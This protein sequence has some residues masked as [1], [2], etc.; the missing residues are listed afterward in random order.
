MDNN[1]LEISASKDIRKLVEQGYETDSAGYISTALD[2]F[3]KNIPQF[4][5][6]TLIYLGASSLLSQNETLQ[7][8][9]SLLL[10]PLGFGAFIVAQKIVKNQDYTFKNFFDGYNRFLDV[11]IYYLIQ[12]VIVIAIAIAI[13]ALPI[14]LFII[15][16]G[17]SG[18][19]N[20]SGITLIIIILIAIIVLLFAFSIGL[21]FLFAPNLLWFSNMR[22]ID[23]LQTSAK[24]IRKKFFNWVGFFFMI[25]GINLLGLLAFG[26][27]L[28]ISIPVSMIATYVAFEHVVGTPNTIE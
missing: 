8:I 28:L 22:A 15:F 19:Q 16:F 2:I 27:G 11:I 26:I 9:S 6:Y 3:K 20:P 4:I 23:A 7:A 12:M 18:F 25:L 21:L 14:I 17:I 24:I 1:D 13:L 10:A 5:L